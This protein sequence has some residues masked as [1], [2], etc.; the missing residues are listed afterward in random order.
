M[1][2]EHFPKIMADNEPQS[3]ELREQIPSRTKKNN[4]KKAHQ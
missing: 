3:Q 2:S 4:K 1:M